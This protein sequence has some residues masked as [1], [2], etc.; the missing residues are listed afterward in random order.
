MYHVYSSSKR[1]ILAI[2]SAI[3][4]NWVDRVDRVDRVDW[5]DSSLGLTK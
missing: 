1:I 3:W 4:Y 2:E 5:V